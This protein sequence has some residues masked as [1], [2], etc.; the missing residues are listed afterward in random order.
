M[1]VLTSI[2]FWA[3]FDWWYIQIITHLH[4]GWWFLLI[5]GT[6]AACW[7]N[8]SGLH[9]WRDPGRIAQRVADMRWGMLLTAKA[10]EARRMMTGRKA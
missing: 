10:E 8:D 6:T 4:I 2:S 9:E 7:M 5:F 1:T 3:L